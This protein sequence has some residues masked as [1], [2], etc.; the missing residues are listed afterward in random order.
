MAIIGSIQNI[1]GWRC[2]NHKTHHKAYRPPSPPNQF[3]RAC[4]LRFH[5]LLHFWDASWKSFSVRMSSTLCDSAWIFSMVPNR[6]PFSFNFI[7]GNRKKSQD[8]KSKEYGGWGMTAI[9]Y[10]ARKCWVKTEV[11]DVTLSW[12]SSRICSRQSSGRS[13]RT[14]SSSRRKTSQYNPEFA[15][16]PVWTGASRY[17][18]CCIDG[19]TSPKYFGYHLVFL[20]VLVQYYSVILTYKLIALSSVYQKLEMSCWFPLLY[21]AFNQLLIV[22]AILSHARSNIVLFIRVNLWK[23]IKFICCSNYW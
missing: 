5:C 10:F 8:V 12:W 19:G 2:K 16:W 17:H 3:P 7:S 18:N 4:R 21:S 11:W 15:V 22:S 9:L 6:R 20:L 23:K 1:P 13:L 14:F